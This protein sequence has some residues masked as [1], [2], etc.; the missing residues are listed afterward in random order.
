M[1]KRIN[2]DEM[3]RDLEARLGVVK[4]L[5]DEA[6]D[7][8]VSL[9]IGKKPPRIYATMGYPPDLI[10]DEDDPLDEGFSESREAAEKFGRQLQ[11]LRR[12]MQENGLKHYTLKN[13]HFKGIDS[14]SSAYCFN[15]DDYRK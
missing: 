5:V 12:I 4:S 1:A 14:F 8:H 15:H 10:R 3:L 7:I 6:L 13:P 2:W 11:V 9:N